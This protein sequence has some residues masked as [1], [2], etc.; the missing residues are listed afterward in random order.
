MLE[1]LAYGS[2]VD[3]HLGEKSCTYYSFVIKVMCTTFGAERPTSHFGGHVG[4]HFGK[5][6]FKYYSFVTK[7]MCT[8]FDAERLAS[9]F[10]QGRPL[11][12]AP[13]LVA[14]LGRKVAHIIL[15]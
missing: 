6:I 13:I 4:G 5:N 2:H 7:I 9:N 1:V 10:S 12:V 11:K 14:I 8:K 3:G 15:M